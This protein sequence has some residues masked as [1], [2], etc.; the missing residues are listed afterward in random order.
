MNASIFVPALMGL[1]SR[2]ARSVWSPPDEPP[3]PTLPPL[4]VVNAG[5]PD[6]TQVTFANSVMDRSISWSRF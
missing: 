1:L 4:Y 3:E 2:L 6:I 5:G